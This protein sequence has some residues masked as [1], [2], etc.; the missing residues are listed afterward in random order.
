MDEAHI[1]G[2]SSITL[3]VRSFS[4]E[5][6]AE[7]PVTIKRNVYNDYSISSG[8]EEGNVAGVTLEVKAAFEESVIGTVLTFSL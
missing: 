3:H 2:R 1:P 7:L 8:R 6:R 5:T 4:N